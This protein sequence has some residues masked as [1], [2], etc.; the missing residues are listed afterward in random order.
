MACI[1]LW[2]RQPLFGL[3]EQHPGAHVYCLVRARD[4]GSGKARIVDAMNMARV[5]LAHY[6]DHISALSPINLA[7]AQLGLSGGQYQQMLGCV[8]HVYHNA[9]HVDHLLPYRALKEANVTGT[10]QVARFC[11]EGG[12]K[13]HYTSSVSATKLGE[14]AEETW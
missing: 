5:Y 14:I 11:L 13:M 2:S 4:A 9:A 1:T 10:L 7:D 3:Q 6:Q 8:G 12:A